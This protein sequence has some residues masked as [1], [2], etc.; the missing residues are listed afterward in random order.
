MITQ[1]PDLMGLLV[2]ERDRQ[3]LNPFADR[4]QR[5]RPGID[6]VRL[7]RGPGRLAGLAGQ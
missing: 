3:V 6:R 1:H 2:Q 7:S 5:D 4:G